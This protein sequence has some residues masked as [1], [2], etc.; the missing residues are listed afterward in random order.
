MTWWYVTHAPAPHLAALARPALPAPPPPIISEPEKKQ[1]PPPDDFAN[2]TRPPPR[3]D[4]GE[5]SGHGTAN[6]S[7]PGQRPME[8][9]A[10]L[11]QANLA[12][13]AKDEP[14]KPDESVLPRQAGAPIGTDTVAQAAPAFG[15]PQPSPTPAPSVKPKLQVAL[16]DTTHGQ[17]PQPVV[18]PPV[19]S[20][21]LGS[22]AGAR[23]LPPS[24]VPT[25]PTTPQETRGHRSL[26][27]DTDSMPFAKATTAHFHNGKMDARLGRRVKTT[28]IDVDLAGRS[29]SWSLTSPTV[30]LGVS[31][32]AAGFVQNV[33]ILR[34]SGSDNID[35]P[36]QR[37]VYDWWFEPQK[38]KNGQPTA[39]KW[40]VTID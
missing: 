34:S 8:A 12:R 32:N 13:N 4:S 9:L 29:D 2:A 33:V 17:R 23:D 39:D 40:V 35:L 36:C 28:W 10:G 1:P 22:P 21:I 19:Q 3:D 16:V 24:P 6:R 5:S 26:T 15:V 18:E 31:V 11:E 27:A 7:T 38:D 37:A 25:L 20:N 14:L 30:V